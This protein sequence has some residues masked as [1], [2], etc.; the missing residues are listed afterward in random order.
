MIGYLRLD[1]SK[2]IRDDSADAGKG[3]EEVKPA[4]IGEVIKTKLNGEAALT[5]TK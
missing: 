1:W 2:I 4:E 5:L 3:M